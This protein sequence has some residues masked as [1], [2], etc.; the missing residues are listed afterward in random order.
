MATQYLTLR[1]MPGTYRMASVL[2]RAAWPAATSPLAVVHGSPALAASASVPAASAA[3]A[4]STKRTR[5]VAWFYATD[6]PKARPSYMNYKSS[7]AASKFEPFTLVES[8]RIERSFQLL[9]RYGAS[10][11]IATGPETDT[12]SDKRPP[13]VL[14][15]VPVKEDGLYQVRIAEREMWPTYWEGDVFEVRRGTWFF[16]NGSKLLPVPEDVAAELEKAHADRDQLEGG[17]RLADGQLVKF[18]DDD[19]QVAWL[20][21]GGGDWT[22]FLT[23]FSTS[24]GSTKKV[25][26]GF[27]EEVK[28]P[29]GSDGA[30]PS[31]INDGADQ[32]PAGGLAD[33]TKRRFEIAKDAAQRPVD[34]LL[35]CVHGIGQ[36]LS[37][38]I[39]SLNF[40]HDIDVFRK[41]IRET[42]GR[43]ETLQTKLNRAAAL[44][45]DTEHPHRANSR[46]QALP[47]VWRHSLTFGH[48]RSETD[49][50]LGDITLE[51]IASLRNIFGD[52]ILDVLL[53]NEPRF[54]KEMLD[55]A[56]LQLNKA[57]RAFCAYNPE[58][59][60]NP[61][62][63]IIGHSLGSVMC[64]DI[65]SEG[66]PDASVPLDLT[67][68]PASDRLEFQV[69]NFF[70]VGSPLGLYKFISGEQLTSKRLNA[71]AYWNVFHPSDPI[72]YRV[73]PLVHH[74]ATHMRPAKVPYTK[75][76]LKTQ[77]EGLSD[78]GNKIS[79][80][81]T[82]LWGSV[83][84]F[85]ATAKPAAEAGN[86]EDLRDAAKSAEKEKKDKERVELSP[87]QQQEV[88]RALK[89]LNPGGRLDF[90]VQEGVLDISVIAALASHMSYFEDP[91]VAHFVLDTL[92]SRPSYRVGT[93]VDYKALDDL[94]LLEE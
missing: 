50:A 47:V 29:D 19:D 52:V 32:D 79:E 20:Y 40:V 2:S 41:Q 70:G 33:A 61:R 9:Q 18:D 63:S 14:N 76:G 74:E 80:Q 12:E 15:I 23:K 55:S 58:F 81:A 57:F 5:A 25:V 53:Y 37:Q 62:V 21:S 31:E 27:T 11:G 69:E 28:V 85:Y 65:L 6:T 51:G 56:R 26:R 64:W 46:V 75:G 90:A 59:A 48:K 30:T 7:K 54:R 36:K 39:E 4:Y 35:L 67:S 3:R 68:E 16:Q 66:A 22:D 78:L 42:F 24:L 44:V 72:A 89:K 77:L 92:Y 83:A 94:R 91:D 71:K 93:R 43:S 84:A 45:V 10:S 38:R 49:V 82:Q 86:A 87:Q 88:T 60:A 34:H 1:R 73:E 8:E 17:A 13:Q